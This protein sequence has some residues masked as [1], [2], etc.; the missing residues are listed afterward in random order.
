MVGGVAGH[1][2]FGDSVNRYGLLRGCAT[3]G[4]GISIGNSNGM[5]AGR[6]PLHLDAVGIGAFQNGAA[7]HIPTIVAHVG[8]GGQRQRVVYIG[9]AGANDCVAQSGRGQ[10]FDGQ[11]KGLGFSGTCG[12]LVAGGRDG[13]GVFTSGGGCASNGV[14][15]EGQTSGKTGVAVA[16]VFCVSE[17]G[18]IG[19]GGSDGHVCNIAASAYALLKIRGAQ[20][21]GRVDGQVEGEGGSGTCGCLVAGGRDGDGVDTGFC[22][23]TSDLLVFLVIA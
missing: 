9:S 10:V 15:A 21:N 1:G 2:E 20:G 11:C 18:S 23:S 16:T 19:I 8:V 6:S 3:F 7:V 4:F 13:D 14:V 17:G 22:R 12:C 5:C